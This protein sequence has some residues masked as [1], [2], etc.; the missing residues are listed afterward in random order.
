MV[1]PLQKYIGKNISLNN[2]NDDKVYTPE[3]IEETPLPNQD[4]ISLVE[5]SGSTSSDTHSPSTI[6]DQGNPRKVVAHELLSTHFNTLTRK[7]LSPFTFTPSGSIRIGDYKEGEFGDI[8]IS[9]NGILGRDVFGE[10]T[11]AIDGE[12]GN[13]TFKGDL[14]SGSVIT[15]DISLEEGGQISIGGS[16]I[17]DDQGIVSSSIADYSD[18]SSGSLLQSITSTSDTQ[19]TDSSI[20]ITVSRSVRLQLFATIQYYL[21]RN[22]GSGDFGAYIWIDIFLDGAQI[23]KFTDIAQVSA[24]YNDTTKNTDG[25]LDAMTHSNI[26]NII[27]LTPGDHT[28]DL[29]AHLTN[30]TGDP[31]LVIYSFNLT[32]VKLGT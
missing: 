9:P 13:A 30:K 18:T 5:S 14:R 10:T 8:S 19:I 3:T 29:K 12:T 24:Y 20:A 2:M 27:T 32:Y 4:S 25:P 1:I 6:K 28:I 7:I 22:S 11:F 21:S 23:G 31:K 15:G 16:P 26:F 17:L